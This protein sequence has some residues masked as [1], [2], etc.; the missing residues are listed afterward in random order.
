MDV[1]TLLSELVKSL[2][3][4]VTT[5]ILVFLLRKPIIDLIPLLRRL[6]YKEFELEFSEEVTQLKA[7]AEA[8]AREKGEAAPSIT[9]NS[10][11][12]LDLV[13][14]STR[15]A[16]MEAWLEVETEAVATASSFWEGA[17]NGNFQ[18][19][20]KLG[21][22]LLEC[23]AIDEKQ[24]A[25][26]NKLRQLRNKAAHAQEL[27]LNENDARSYV[28]LASDLARHIHKV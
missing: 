18:N 22:Y 11:Q 20:P 9:A 25:V 8:I 21:E 19:M 13:S 27:D 17:S 6:K 7:E 15:A 1:Q 23:N 10:N 28:Q 5:I 3:W 24:L 16:I 2:A 14:F 4:P 12:L 26:F